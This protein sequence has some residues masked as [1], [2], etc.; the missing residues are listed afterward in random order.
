MMLNLNQFI[1]ELGLFWYKIMLQD[2][3]NYQEM[4]TYRIVLDLNYFFK[5]WFS[6]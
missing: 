2:T 4:Q 6:N 5:I 1:Y 3:L